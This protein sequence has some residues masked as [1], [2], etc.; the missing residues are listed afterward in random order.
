MTGLIWINPLTECE[1]NIKLAKP[2]RIY[3]LIV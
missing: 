1:N 2:K 3:P